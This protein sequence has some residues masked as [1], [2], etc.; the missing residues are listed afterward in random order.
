M[1]TYYKVTSILMIIGGA[2]TILAGIG[3]LVF[4]S[5]L[6][7]VANGND[8]G[9]ILY[10]ILSILSG[11][12]ELVAGIFGV[13][14]SSRPMLRR[15]AILMG[16]ITIVLIFVVLLASMFGFDVPVAWYTWFL[17][18]IVPVLFLIGAFVSK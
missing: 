11:V 10:P 6:V 4:S 5:L 1:Q 17:S 2:A 15:L 16:L 9:I 12:A 18:L 3:M 14:S 7:T 8:V 13:Q